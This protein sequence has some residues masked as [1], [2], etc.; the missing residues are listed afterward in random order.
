MQEVMKNDSP[1]KSFVEDTVEDLIPH[2]KK[3]R[4]DPEVKYVKVF[5]GNTLKD[6]KGIK[7]NFI[8][9]EE[10][11]KSLMDRICEARSFG[12]TNEKRK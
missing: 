10:E 8:H 5:R 6:E 2:I 1:G 4:E 3:S 12:E 11:K 9:A 7:K